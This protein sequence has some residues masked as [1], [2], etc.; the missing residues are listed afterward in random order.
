MTKGAQHAISCAKLAIEHK[1]AL[2][3]AEFH[4]ILPLK[5]EGESCKHRATRQ[6]RRPEKSGVDERQF[7]LAT[8][9]WH[10]KREKKC[11][12]LTQHA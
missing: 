10:G 6:D 3:W 7:P 11:I 12:I 5:I 8:L 1:N 2:L 4:V 9:L